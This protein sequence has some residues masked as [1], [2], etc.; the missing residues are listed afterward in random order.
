MTVPPLLIAFGTGKS[1]YLYMGLFAA[2]LGIVFIIL[3]LPGAHEDKIM[4]DRFYSGKYERSPFFRGI[5][6]VLKQKSFLAFIVHYTSFSVATTIMTAIIVYATTFI[7]RVGAD[8]ITI[9]FGISLLGALISVPFWLRMFKKVNNNK[10]VYTIGSFVLC[11]A[12][13]PLTFFQSIIDFAVFMF[14]V[15]FAM[16]CVW[17][18]G[19]PWIYSSVQ[20]D[21]V[22][23]TERNQKGVLVGTWAIFTLVTAFLDEAIISTVY[24]L[25]GFFAGYDT[26]E[27]LEAVVPNITPILWGIRFLAGVI[28]SLVIL[29]GTLVFWKFFPLTQDKILEN[30]AKLMELGF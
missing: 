12:L 27:A 23:R 5:W 20:D 11:L 21:Y 4:I 25:T 10:K 3:F 28:P 30:K 24:S 14:I 7:L 2:V 15:G 17:T 16:G 29:I 19:I 1:A 26:Y 13:I 8:T 6:D 9:L 22:A 18:S